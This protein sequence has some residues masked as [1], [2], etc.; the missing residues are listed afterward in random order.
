[1]DLRGYRHVGFDG[2]ND[3]YLEREF[4]VPEG[5]NLPTQVSGGLP[6]RIADLRH[7]VQEMQ[8]NFTAAE[9]SAF[10]L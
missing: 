1:M 3:F 7:Q 2:A 4:A 9:E 5:L 8:A 6:P 10:S